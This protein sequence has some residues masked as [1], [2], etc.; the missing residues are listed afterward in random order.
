M[1]TE[2]DPVQSGL[3]FAVR[4]AKGEFVG[5]AAFE[6]AAGAAPARRLRCLTVDDGTSLVLGKEPVYVGG[7]AAGYITS[8][9]FGHTVRKPV[10]YA[11]LPGE[12]EVGDSVEIDYFGTRI[13]ATV[14]AEPLV[15]PEMAKIRA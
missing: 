2:H 13:A 10:A 5:K 11:W 7:T 1:T 9:A 14:Q 3:D 4:P 8:A 6:A 15:D 12:V